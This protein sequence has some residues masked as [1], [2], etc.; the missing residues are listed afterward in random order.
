[1]SDTL[2]VTLSV[3]FSLTLVSALFLAISATLLLVSQLRSARLSLAALETSPTMEELLDQRIAALD[4]L[5]DT[6]RSSE[7]MATK[8]IERAEHSDRR[9]HAIFTA[10]AADLVKRIRFTDDDVELLVR[11]LVEEGVLSDSLEILDGSHLSPYETRR[12]ESLLQVI[13]TGR[14]YA[15]RAELLAVESDYFGVL[16]PEPHSR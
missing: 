5:I 9:D 3:L 15:R 14:E 13:A 16:P 2:V 10:D 11:D 12:L 1:M 8:R 6:Y 7:T 4:E